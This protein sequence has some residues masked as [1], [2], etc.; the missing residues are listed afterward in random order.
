M[1]EKWEMMVFSTC[2]N[3]VE[4]PISFWQRS[5]ASYKQKLF[6]LNHKICIKH[7]C[8][9]T[10]FSLTT[11]NK[12]SHHFVR[13]KGSVSCKSPTKDHTVSPQDSVISTVREKKAF[14]QCSA[15]K[16]MINYSSTYYL[17]WWFASVTRRRW[18][19]MGR[20]GWNIGKEIGDLNTKICPNLHNT[21]THL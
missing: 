8:A 18:S 13:D 14:R 6:A 5:L 10:A 16:Q 1:S 15:N 20:A 9:R 19:P 17:V 12:F 11:R 2:R 4:R 21:H 3:V 7:H